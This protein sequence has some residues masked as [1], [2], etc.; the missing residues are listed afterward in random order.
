MN[1]PS[2]HP[3]LRHSPPLHPP[4]DPAVQK[5]PRLARIAKHSKPRLLPRHSNP[6]EVHM[7]R[8][9]LVPHLRKR[10]AI[11]L[12]PPMA[13]HRPHVPLRVVVLALGKPVVDEKGRPLPKP[14]RQRRNERLRLRMHL[15]E[16]V[17][18]PRHL[19]RRPQLGS[20]V[21]PRPPIPRRIPHH[22][23]LEPSPLHP[24][25]QLHRHRI[26]HFIADHH[27]LHGLRQL[28]EPLDPPRIPRQRLLLPLAQGARQIDDAVAHIAAPHLAQRM[29]QL[30]RQRPRARAEFPHRVG[31]GLLQR[32]EHLHRERV[33]EHR[34]QL[35]RGHEVAAGRGHVA[36]LG[37]GV[38][39]V[40][41]PRRIQGQGHEA[42]EAD[43]SARA[44]DGAG[45]QM[46]E[47]DG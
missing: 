8:D 22:P 2:R 10:I 27:A 42:V 13:H 6:R 47:G 46:V 32:L 15:R 35:G 44:L 17:V 4:Q 25:Q 11:R 20:P 24:R 3:P 5:K 31:T 19:D 9:V 23:P 26:E 41:Q 7:R 16:V 36:E 18:H 40:A 12:M 21:R 45:N 33:A 34:R 38:G 30:H 43:P 29:Q 28:P 37:R 39:V 1:Q 14:I